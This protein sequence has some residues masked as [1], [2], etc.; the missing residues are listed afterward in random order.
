MK[1]LLWLLFLLCCPTLLRGQVNP[2]TGNITAA[3]PCQATSNS[4]CVIQTLPVNASSVAV[5]VGNT[6]SATLA[7]EQSAD[8]GNTWTSAG[9]SITSPGVTTYTITAQNV[10][11]VRPSSYS[12]GTAT[13]TIL[14]STAPTGAA[15]AVSSVF[16]R[17]GIVVSV[18]GDYTV[19]Q[20]TGAVPN[21]ITVNGHALNGNVT[22]TN[23]DLGAVPT[24]TTVAGHALSSNVSIAC[25]DL[26]N[27]GSGC[28][29]ASGVASVS[30][31]ANQ[32]SSTGGA[33]P[34]LSIPTAFTLPGTLTSAQNGALSAPAWTLSGAPIS[35][36]SGT[37]TVPLYYL[38]CAG[39]TQPSTWNTNGTVFGINTCSGLSA[40]ALIFDFHANGGSSLFA[41]QAGGQLSAQTLFS[42]GSVTAGATT[43]FVINTRSKWGSSVDGIATFFNNAATGF[44]RLNFGGVTS[45][46][47]AFQVNG[48]GLQAELADGSAQTNFSAKS[49]STETNCAN[50]ASPAVCGS[51]AS[52]AVAI[53][54]GSTPT[55][56]V[57]TTAV[58]ANS[59]IVLT[60]DESLTISGVTCNTTLATLTQPV[61]T[62]RS[63]GA[64]F[65]IQIGS[66]LATNPACV[67]YMVFN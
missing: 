59:R 60:I 63:A 35:G 28:S 46:F 47:P 30:G 45:S 25:G 41:L 51:A 23:S 37:T 5:T 2:I 61:V 22:V 4:S 48:T 17:T 36:G 10:F 33:N 26:S 34:T 20:V 27:A 62:A 66:T 16:G 57:N 50:G 14:Y 24:S 7:P 67:S 40:N 29:S 13:V 32:V 58:T 64:S 12:S 65:T 43:Q 49:Y 3:G 53:P 8:S 9:S 11:R 6:F 44:T 38:N 55:L 56:Q 15:G 1:R 52:G 21:T 18:S 39:S 54:T 42:S 19:D 31:T